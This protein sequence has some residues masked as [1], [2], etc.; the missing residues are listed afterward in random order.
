[1]KQDYALPLDPNLRRR[2]R[3]RRL[4][5]RTRRDGWG[6]ASREGEHSHTQRACRGRLGSD[7]RVYPMCS[8]SE[9]RQHHGRLSR[10][11]GSA[12]GTTCVVA[13][14]FSL[15]ENLPD[16]AERHA[17]C[18]SH[19]PPD[20]FE[21]GLPH[22]SHVRNR[23]TASLIRS[24]VVVII[25]QLHTIHHTYSLSLSLWEPLNIEHIELFEHTR[26]EHDHH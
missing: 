26:N 12:G 6:E 16:A 13:S 18:P 15:Q 1:M 3:A 9:A 19:S 24:Y 4:A 22:P 11:R 2:Q 10:D 20:P 21:V 17:T 5:S 8:E 23:K 14:H 25:Q 7:G